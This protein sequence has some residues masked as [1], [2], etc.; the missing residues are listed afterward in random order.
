MSG[1]AP[2]SHSDRKRTTRIVTWSCLALIPVLAIL[3]LGTAVLPALTGDSPAV[4]GGLQIAD[5][6]ALSA[7]GDDLASLN[8][9]APANS[10]DDFMNNWQDTVR[11]RPSPRR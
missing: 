7:L 6:R 9:A 11:R 10:L 8:Q 4:P 3:T 1:N 2:R 5:T